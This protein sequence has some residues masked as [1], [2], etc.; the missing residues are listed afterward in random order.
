M[1]GVAGALFITITLLVVIVVC[2]CCFGGQL[3]KDIS[4]TP[5]LDL[6]PSI[7]LSDNTYTY[8]KQLLYDDWEIPRHI[9]EVYKNETLG[10]GCFGEVCKGGLQIQFLKTRRRSSHSHKLKY[11]HTTD[12][13]PVAIKTLKSMSVLDNDIYN[14]AYYNIHSLE[15][16]N[17]KERD[18]FLKEIETMKMVSETDNELKRFVVN[19]MGCCRLEEPILL[20]VEFMQNG[21][22]LNYIRSMKKRTMVCR[23]LCNAMYRNSKILYSVIHF[24]SINTISICVNLINQ[25]FILV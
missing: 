20:V 7:N 23:H 14:Y 9:L 12:I 3:K 4:M 10:S 21:D 25:S 15:T 24:R 2:C 11:K 13:L 8:S 6:G 22:L 19:M 17:G 1:V 18:D 16:A 5:M